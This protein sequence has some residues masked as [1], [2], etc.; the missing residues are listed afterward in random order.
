[1]A[2]APAPGAVRTG[3]AGDAFFTPP[4][5]MPGRAHGDAIW[6]RELTGQ[7][8]LAEARVNQAV[9][10]RSTSLAGKPIAVSGTIHLPN[11]RM[12]RGPA[13]RSCR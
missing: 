4:K 13:G 2:S 6:V 9:L 10:Y 7:Q 12:C 8:T 11:G 3:P 5:P 1:V